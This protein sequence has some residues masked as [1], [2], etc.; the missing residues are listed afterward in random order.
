MDLI[1]ECWEEWIG[2]M[3]LKII[4]LVLEGYEWRIVIGFD[5]KNIGWSYF[6]GEF[7]LG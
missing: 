1:E 5:L 4:Y 2:E 6:I 3:F 7:W